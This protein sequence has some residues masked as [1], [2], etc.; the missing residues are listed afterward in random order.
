MR[1]TSPV[2]APKIVVNNRVHAGE[3]SSSADGVVAEIVGN[4]GHAIAEYSDVEDPHSGDELL[5]EAL[6]NFGRLDCLIA[7]AG[8]LD[9]KTFRKLELAEIRHVMNINFMGT[10]NAVHPVFRHMVDQPG[11]QYCSSAH[12][13]QVYL[14]SSACRHTRRPKRL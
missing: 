4:G 7:N 12:H 1:C 6:N 9:N 10:V 3:D 2:V 14:G 13:R 5:A 8:I 11:R